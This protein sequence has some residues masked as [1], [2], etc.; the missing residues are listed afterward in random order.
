MPKVSE[1]IS[2]A[3]STSQGRTDANLANDALHLG[4]IEANDYA[5]KEYVQ[6]YHNGKEST[7]KQYIGQKDQAMLNEAKEYTNSQIRNQDFSNFAELE[8]LQALNTNLSSQITEG[9]NAQKQ[10]TDQIT[11]QIVSDTNANFKD[12]EDAIGS[13]NNN[14]NSLFQSVSNGKSLIA[15]AIT[16]KGVPTSASDSYSTMASNIR[17]IPSGGSGTDPNYV[18]TSDATATASDILNGKTAY[19]KGQ[20]VYG[21]LIAQAEEGMPTYGTDTSNATATAADIVYG[22]TAYA[23]SQLI[24]GTL[25]NSNVEEIYGLNTENIESKAFISNTM[26]ITGEIDIGTNLIAF[27]KNMDY[28]VRQIQESGSETRYIESFQVTENGFA[29]QS[30]TSMG[31]EVSYKKYRYTMSE[32]GIGEDESITSI[33]FGPQFETNKCY[34]YFLTR[35]DDTDTNNS[36]CK[37]YVKEYHLNDNGVIGKEY[38]NQNVVD[39]TKEIYT[40]TTGL[41]GDGIVVTYNNSANSFLIIQ[42][43]PYSSYGKSSKIYK[44][45]VTLNQIFIAENPYSFSIPSRKSFGGRNNYTMSQNDKYVYPSNR[46]LSYTVYEVVIFLDNYGNV[47]GVEENTISSLTYLPETDTFTG[48]YGLEGFNACQVKY[49]NQSKT[50]IKKI[51]LNGISNL[52]NVIP[53]NNKIIAI[54]INSSGENITIYLFD[55][56]LEEI[57]DEE[58]I[59]Y[60][61][62]MSGGST[63]SISDSYYSLIFISNDFKKVYSTINLNSNSSSFMK[64]YFRQLLLDVDIQNIIGVKYKNK[65]F[66]AAK[67]QLTAIATDV[68][69]GKTFIGENGTVETGTMEVTE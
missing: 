26:D 24:T 51:N 59:D 31:G 43:S 18:N 12:V 28:C 69:A 46:S 22:K 29:Y 9:L 68:V 57:Q 38:D 67:N 23:R 25:L 19:V 16:D 39:L 60:T 10:Y 62:T 30:S 35:K 47:D 36:I 7:L 13:L 53:I 1:Q 45:E 48:Y 20:K 21:T 6:E 27:S 33:A 64:S 65:T 5:T 61:Q 4:G 17:S 50:I 40:E 11:N 32:L 37:L 66:Y 55:K 42:G 14:V 56:S 3:N 49:E 58:T 34:I 44:G 52:R 41:F 15:G 2:K 63:D 54:G 8:D